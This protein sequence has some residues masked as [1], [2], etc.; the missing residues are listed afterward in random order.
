MNYS[1]EIIANY[2]EKNNL[3]SNNSSLIKIK[4]KINKLNSSN[5]NSKYNNNQT[6]HNSKIMFLKNYN[7]MFKFN[8]M[9]RGLLQ[10]KENNQSL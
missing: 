7:H 3:N 9:M 4:L 8:L 5:N 6:R 10:V 1:E 2:I